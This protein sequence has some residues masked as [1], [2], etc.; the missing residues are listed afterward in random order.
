MTTTFEEYRPWVYTNNDTPVDIPEGGVLTNI[1]T[2]SDTGLPNG[3]YKV[4][5]QLVW[6]SDSTSVSTDFV[7]TINGYTTPTISEEL[8]NKDDNK[9]LHYFVITSV[10]D[11]NM[12]ISLDGSRTTGSGTVST[13]T[14]TEVIY[15]RKLEA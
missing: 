11:G 14:S 15:E 5:I 8:V 13:V 3:T 2:I 10:T 7:A 4:S 6:S 9:A 12:N 1:M